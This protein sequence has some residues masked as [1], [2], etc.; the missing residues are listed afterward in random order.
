MAPLGAGLIWRCSRQSFCNSAANDLPRP[1]MPVNAKATQMMPAISSRAASW[2]IEKLKLKTRMTM[3]AKKNID[4]MVS[5]LRIS[6]T[7][8]F[9]PPPRIPLKNGEGRELVG[10]D[11][12][13]TPLVQRPAPLRYLRGWGAVVGRH[14][15]R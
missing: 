7:R 11:V 3:S 8:S 10:G 2:S 1:M 12:A 4:E 15:H 14:Q 5:R 6:L 9:H 13:Q